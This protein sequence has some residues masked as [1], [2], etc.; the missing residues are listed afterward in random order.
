MHAEDK[1]CEALLSET[2]LNDLFF[3]TK[4]VATWVIVLI[5]PRHSLQFKLYELAKQ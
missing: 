1:K 2:Q 5:A 3:I 4:E